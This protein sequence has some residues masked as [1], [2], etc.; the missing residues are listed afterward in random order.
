MN[1]SCSFYFFEKKKE[2]REHVKIFEYVIRY[3]NIKETTNIQT[4][5]FWG[6]LDETI[7]PF[8]IVYKS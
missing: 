8:I 5:N 6:K 3:A 1:F 4:N 2:G 7:P